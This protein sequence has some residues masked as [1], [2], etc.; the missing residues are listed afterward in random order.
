MRIIYNR[1]SFKIENYDNYV[2]EYIKWSK[3]MGKPISHSKLRIEPYNLP[4]A[5][6]FVNHCPDENVNSWSDFINWCGFPAHGSPLSKEKTAELIYKMQEHLDRPLMYEDFKKR[7][8]YNVSIN[9]VR[10][11]WGT[12]NKMKEALGLE[13]VQE[14]M[15]D[16]TLSKDEFEM[17]LLQIFDFVKSEN[18]NFITTREIDNN[19]N[20][21]NSGTLNKY[22]TKYFNTT[23]KSLLNKYDISLGEQGRGINYTFTDGEHVTSQFEYIFSKFLKD[24]NLRYQID[25]FRDVKY[26]SFIPNYL[27]QRNCDYVID[28]NGKTLYIEIAGVLAEYK[29]WY[30]ENKVISNRKSREKY[31]LKLKEKENLLKS[32][33]LLYF[34]LFPCDLTQDTMTMVLGDSSLD[35]K[36]K[37][38]SFNQHNIDWKYVRKTGEL[39]YSKP[40]LTCQNP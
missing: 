10:K 35:V 14:S 11:Y 39:D 5:S 16:K 7:G 40:F 30:Y 29:E 8:V 26:S 32:N 23:L 20:W 17:L 25:Y 37:I 15:M 2:Q 1:R 22:A 4:N 9:I 34:I 13:I 31:R 28:I 3:E 27:G 36:H 38:E 19:K 18:R 33:G 21:P 6:W 12:L 24:N